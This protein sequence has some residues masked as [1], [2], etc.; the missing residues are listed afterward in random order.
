M[1]VL[2]LSRAALSRRL[3]GM[4]YLLLLPLGVVVGA[5]GTMIGAGGGFILMPI[6]LLAYPGTDPATLTAVSLAVVFFNAASGSY[7][8]AR[9]KRVDFKSGV[10]FLL[11][12][13]PGAVAGAYAIHFVPR[14][15]FNLAFGLFL[16]A[17][18]L[19][20][21][22]RTFVGGEHENRLRGTFRRTLIDAEGTQHV[23]AYNLALGMMLSF[24]VGMASSMLGIGGGIIHVPAMVNL[25]DFPVHI[26]TATSHFILAVM[27]LTAT[28]M[29]VFDGALGWEELPRV[30][31]IAAGAVV[32]AQIGARL[33]GRIHG[34]WILRSLAI[35]LALVGIRILV[36]VLTRM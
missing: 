16:L 33:S 22:L 18:G 4:T 34:R 17:G 3:T 25:L 5:F 20:I 10:L 8:Y 23:Y 14:Q 29:H 6:L 1:C 35:A 13:I 27:S 2:A 7:S 28:V 26:A 36:P 30:L 9:M 31:A 24:G 15:A 32:G 12:G 21:F 11:P 19:F